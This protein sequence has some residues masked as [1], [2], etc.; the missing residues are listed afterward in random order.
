MAKR[1]TFSLIVLLIASALVFVS[2]SQEAAEGGKK[3]PPKPAQD[4]PVENV[5]GEVSENLIENGT[6]DVENN[7]GVVSDEDAGVTFVEGLGIGGSNAIDVIT[8]EKYGS[9]NIDFTEFYGRGKSYYV[10]ASF[11]NNGSVNTSDP[12]AHIDVTVV[13]GA[14]QD[15]VKS[16]GWEGYYDCDD[17]YEGGVLSDDDALD[18]FEIETSSG[19]A[20]LSDTEWVTVSCIIDAETIEALL[21]N[22]T[23]KYGSGDPT[24][25]KLMAVFYVGHNDAQDNYHY[26]VDNI[27]IKDLNAELDVEGKTYE[28]PGEEEE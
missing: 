3:I 24:I 9:I 8:V 22:T 25:Y 4:E 20:T 11:K 14:V 12:T 1:I 2:C 21:V 6:F 16:Q 13:S 7:K 27:V 15:A 23:N 26:L 5:L 19:G 17:I 28:A 10:E 18:L